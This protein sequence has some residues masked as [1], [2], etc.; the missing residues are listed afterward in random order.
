MSE[1]HNRL[2]RY[3]SSR[4]RKKFS[5]LLWLISVS[6]SVLMVRMWYLQ[7]I[8]GE[9][10]RQ[11]SENNRIRIHE[12]KPLRG[13]L[14]D[15][16]GVFLAGNQPCF[17]VTIIPGS[18]RDIKAVLRTMEGFYRE[19][20]LDFYRTEAAEK[21]R[22][23]ISVKVAKNISRQELA[24]VESHSVELPGV[25]VEVVPV[26]RYILGE[27]TAHVLG[28]VSEISP[29]ELK[30]DESR[31]YKQGDR[32]GKFGIER[33]LDKY[34]KGV[35]GGEH[36]E[37]N[38][39]GRRV[40]VLGKVDP[41]SGH[42]AILTL[43]ADLQRVAWE[44]MEGRAGSAVA[45][46]PRDGSVLM[47]V[48]KPAFDPNLFNQG[49][50]SSEWERLSK[51]PGRPL[52]NKAIAGQYP[53]GSTYKM[54]VA[55]AGLE[56]GVIT[57][58]TAF[59]CSGS[60]PFGNRVYRCWQKKGHGRVSLHRAVVQSCD[61][62]FYN[63]ARLLGPDTLAKY[64]RKFG[65]GEPTGIDLLG[66]KGGLVP[67][68]DWKLR[69]FKEPW[70]AGETLSLGIGQGFNLLT[71]IQLASA[72]A[73]LGNGG[74]IYR[75]KL[76]KRIETLDRQI[77]KEYEPQIKAKAD[78][79]DETRELV[80]SALWGVCNEG[81][82]TGGAL[83]RKEA[84]VAGKTGTAQ[85][86]TMKEREQ[87]VAHQF[88]DHALF[89]AF[90]PWDKPEIAIAVVVEHGGHGGSTAG[91]VARK[92]IDEYFRKKA[93]A[94]AQAKAAQAK[95]AQAKAKAAEVKTAEA[96]P[97]EAPGKPQPEA[98]SGRTEEDEEESE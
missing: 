28:Y 10:L 21:A 32:I 16:N 39:S 34:L 38:V 67:T 54:I 90:A 96:K 77:L 82:G 43:D 8:K 91:P 42:N 2:S 44:A 30:T 87:S 62:Y 69:R 27:M 81:G 64:A 46:D 5:I 24:I 15:S 12:I 6:L 88:R 89:V 83:R 72:Y 20:G 33:F 84:D 66:E 65:L 49:I 7:I 56:E 3:D 79:S 29:E 86:V 63:V 68:K 85:V 26:R 1:N 4:F 74:I 94:A 48:S 18:N 31:T 58:D 55:V 60:L 47:M 70:Q 22:S 14:I 23:F 9:E 36:V 53:P 95:A 17:D 50:P 80:R 75:P 40:R 25:A 76:V 52:E 97:D 93:A 41:V 37:V 73:A 13:A 98:Q 78:I 35:S 11:R 61:V 57:P 45:L 92:V 19:Q 51:D 71:P 59:T